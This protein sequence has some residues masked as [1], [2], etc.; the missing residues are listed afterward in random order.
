MSAKDTDTARGE[1]P[2]GADEPV[3]MV[4]GEPEMTANATRSWETIPPYDP[5]QAVTGDS[6]PETSAGMTPE[7]YANASAPGTEGDQ[8]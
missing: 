7:E 1:T 5:P 6:T 8:P 2:H 4:D 3:S